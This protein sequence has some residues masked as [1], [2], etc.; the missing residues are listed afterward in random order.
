M[1]WYAHIAEHFTDI[2]EKNPVADEMINTKQQGAHIVLTA[3]W[4]V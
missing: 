2:W 4:M 3:G 1:T